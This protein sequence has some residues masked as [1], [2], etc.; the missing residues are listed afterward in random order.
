[1]FDRVKALIPAAGRGK[2]LAG[3]S[4]GGPKE[5]LTV[6]PLT[7]I[8]HCL[9]MV[10]ES[11]VTEVGVVI[12]PA[13][14]AVRRIAEEF[15][16]K[17]GLDASG[18]TF[19]YQDQPLGVADAMG[20]ATDFAGN[21][22]LAVIM[23]DNMLVGGPPALG[24]ILGGFRRTGQCT[25][26]AIPM[27]AAR[28]PLFGNVGRVELAENPAGG[29]ALVTSF[30]PKGPGDLAAGGG[31]SFK[32]L[33]GVVYLPGWSA[34]IDDLSPNLE[35]EIDDTDLVTKLVLAGQLRAVVLEGLGFDLGH[36]RGLEAARQALASGRFH[37]P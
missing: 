15:W 19:F 14:E 27:S 37:A 2:R 32:G 33:I 10:A 31:G 20:L 17:H 26:G 23:P 1:M 6:G 28:A 24:Q 7:M 18:L 34:M 11:G 25:M 3:V 16:R 12:R 9:A 13:K 8:E 29:P 4:G 35:G 21:K 5:L 36:E 30:S 22:P